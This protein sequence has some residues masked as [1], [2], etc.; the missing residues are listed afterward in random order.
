MG[1]SSAAKKVGSAVKAVAVVVVD[2]LAY[3]MIP[4]G[5]SEL[6]HALFTQGS[7]YVPY[8]QE[9]MPGAEPDAVSPQTEATVAPASVE[10]ASVAEVKPLQEQYQDLVAMYGQRSS[11]QKD[12][13]PSL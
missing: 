7:G 11:P 1:F 6:A 2:T 3:R 5:A 4:H 9:S 10:S 8:G 13:T 12:Q